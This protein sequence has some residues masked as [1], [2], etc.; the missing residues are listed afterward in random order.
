MRPLSHVVANEMWQFLK[1][2]SHRVAERASDRLAHGDAS[3][4]M[5]V[6]IG[7]F[8]DNCKDKRRTI[9]VDPVLAYYRS[10]RERGD[11]NI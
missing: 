8:L 4:F 1:E 9:A 2:K 5:E 6:L 10:L 11:C 7:V 3:G